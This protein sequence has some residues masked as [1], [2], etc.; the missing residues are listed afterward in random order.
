[1]DNADGAQEPQSESESHEES[2]GN[3]MSDLVGPFYSE[4]GVREMLGDSIGDYSL[5]VTCASDGTPFYPVFQFEGKIPKQNV[6]DI[7]AILLISA[8]AWT[9]GVWLNVPQVDDPQ[10]RTALELLEIGERELVERAAKE[11]AYRWSQ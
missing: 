2:T 3:R 7:A 6:L 4:E 1:M 5:L 8:D 10:R 11:A 9:A